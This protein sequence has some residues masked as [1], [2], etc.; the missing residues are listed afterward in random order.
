VID[1]NNIWSTKSYDTFSRSYTN[2][3]D[4]T[5]NA[6]SFRDQLQEQINKTSGST[7]RP[8]YTKPD[9]AGVMEASLATSILPPIN[10]TKVKAADWL[11]LKPED[12]SMEKF[13]EKI[14]HA[15]YQLSLLD[16]DVL[17]RWVTKPE[18]NISR[19]TDMIA[20]PTFEETVGGVIRIDH[21]VSGKVRNYIPCYQW[22]KTSSGDGALGSVYNQQTPWGFRTMFIRDNSARTPEGY[23]ENAYQQEINTYLESNHKE[24]RQSASSSPPAELNWQ[25]R[26]QFYNN[27]AAALLANLLLNS[28]KA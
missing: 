10:G 8:D 22:R 17:P 3:N 6:L 19:S 9:L 20:P 15:N 27:P 7:S 5:T 4:N 25:E 16:P 14:A 21:T 12:Y 18:P 1:T 26:L 11:A 28:D 13:L 23:S 24:S 2:N